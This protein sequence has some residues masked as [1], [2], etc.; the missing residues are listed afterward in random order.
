MFQGVLYTCE[1]AIREAWLERS[2]SFKTSYVRVYYDPN[3]I[4]NCWIKSEVGFEPLTIV[5][6]QRKSTV[7]CVWKRYLI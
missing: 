3:S 4:E 2:H 6:Q 1:T 7:D 5:P